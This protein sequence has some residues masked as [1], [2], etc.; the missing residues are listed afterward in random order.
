MKKWG[1]YSWDSGHLCLC[2]SSLWPNTGHSLYYLC[3]LFSYVLSYKNKTGFFKHIYL[4]QSGPWINGNERVRH[5]SQI[6][7]TQASYPGQYFGINIKILS[8]VWYWTASD[9]KAWVL[10][11]W[12]VCSTPSLPLLQGPLWARV[13]V[14]LRV[15]SLNQIDVFKIICIW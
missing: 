13:V 9:H 8:W 4:I 6:S 14:P 1:I 15:L 2:A 7:K 3:F 11:I 10:V 5:T 12:G